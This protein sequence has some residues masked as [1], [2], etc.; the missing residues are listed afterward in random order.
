LYK[1]ALLDNDRIILATEI[2][3]KEE[4]DIEDFLDPAL[5]VDL[6]NRTYGLK[7]GHELTVDKLDSADQTTVRLVKKAEA[8]FRVLPNETPEF[9][10]YDPSLY[11]LQHPE[12]FKGKSKATQDTLTRFES[13]FER[14]AKFI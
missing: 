2:A 14:L 6:V 8:Y 5:F 10:H 1:A 11:L 13:T 4:A 7:G 12:L 9:S 3:G